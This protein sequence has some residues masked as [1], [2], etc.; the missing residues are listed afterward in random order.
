MLGILSCCTSSPRPQAP[1]FTPPPLSG[2]LG[3]HYFIDRTGP[4][5]P[6]GALALETLDL[7]LFIS[8]PN[9]GCPVWAAFRRHIHVFIF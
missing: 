5:D 3:L 2:F 7:S 8:S 6:F 9:L 4:I 1:P